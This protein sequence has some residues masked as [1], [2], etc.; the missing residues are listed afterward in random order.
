[1]CILISLIITAIVTTR[2]SAIKTVIRHHSTVDR[3]SFQIKNISIIAKVKSPNKATP[4][5]R[6]QYYTTRTNFVVINLPI[7]A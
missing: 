6:S 7:V 5:K 4:Y 2:P 3:L 1:M